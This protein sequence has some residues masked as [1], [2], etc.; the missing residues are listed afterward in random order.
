MKT[1]QGHKI[2]I[3][4]IAV[5]PPPATPMHGTAPPVYAAGINRSRP[6]FLMLGL[7]IVYDSYLSNRNEL[8]RVLDHNDQYFG[9]K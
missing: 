4:G 9:K 1:N 5:A 8:R 6:H 7:K 2:I 3:A